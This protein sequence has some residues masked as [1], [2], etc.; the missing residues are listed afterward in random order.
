MSVGRKRAFDKAEALETAMRVFWD[1]GFN[2]TSL[3]DLTSA[4]GVNKPS[5]YAAFGNK[6]QLF[7]AALE[8]Y[9]AQYGAPLLQRLAKPMDAPLSERVR[10]YLFGI[11]DLVSDSGTPKGC[12]FVRSSCES[13]SAAVPEQISAML[14]DMGLD[15]ERNL[16]DLLKAEQQRGQ[17]PPGA[18]P[19]AIAGYLL[20]VMYGLSVLARRGKPREE[21]NAIV[22][23]AVRM[24]PIADSQKTATN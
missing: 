8:H 22:D 19:E 17:L 12:L 5:L 2:G 23:T 18:H 6:E 1:K 21:L 4:L 7:A 16:T 13:G 14:Q 20:S 10:A 9:M 11:L 24:L 3:T 15:S